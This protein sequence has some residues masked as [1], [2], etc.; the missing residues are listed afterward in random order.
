MENISGKQCTLA[1]DALRAGWGVLLHPED[2]GE[3]GKGCS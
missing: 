1:P 2:F 3:P